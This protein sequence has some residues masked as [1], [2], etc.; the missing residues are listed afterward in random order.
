MS[1]GWG[2]TETDPERGA[3][4]H[5]A[6]DHTSRPVPGRLGIGLNVLVQVLLSIAIFAGVNYLGYRYYMR[7]DLTPNESHTLSSTTLNFLRKLS[8]DVQMTLLFSRGSRVA[9]DMEALADEYR[10][11][12]KK[13]IKVQFID[14]AR[15]VER[16]EQLK[17]E[18]GVTLSQN[19]VLIRANE[20][21][22]YITE[23]EILIKSPGNDTTRPV[24]GFRG[25]DAV[26]SALI[27]VL[28]GRQRIFYVVA[29]KG[30]RS[31]DSLMGALNN[32]RDI[33]RKQNFE[34]KVLTLAELTAVP[35]DADGVILAGPRYDFSDREMAIVRDYWNRKR[36]TVLVLLDPASQTPRLDAFLTEYGVKPRGDRVLFAESTGAGPRKEFSVQA[37]FNAEFSITRPQ[38]DAVT[39]LSGQTES[40]QIL[41]D[42]PRLREQSV[43]VEP[44]IIA[45]PR[46]WGERN[47]LDEL[48]VAGEGDATAPVYVAAAV[49]RGAVPDP[50]LRV[51]SARL[52][53]VGNCDLLDRQT[54]LAANEDFITN[55]LNW[56]MNREKLI[57]IP[58]KVKS[59]YRIQLS[60]HQHDLLFWLTSLAAPG[61]VLSLGLV[62]WASRRAA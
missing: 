19:G 7:W 6:G 40:L 16:A 44:L 31:G 1:A 60:S 42:D 46:Y 18:S 21:T 4:S 49:E 61:L 37:G 36:A 25:E 2:I 48:P 17:A 14:P 47:Y 53:V 39:T 11:N 56:M 55:S 15:D 58:S 29:G 23:D 9:D 57:G 28:E 27:S 24:L 35:A 22:R 32:L 51:D 43:I 38:S 41:T 50:R 33:G 3:S 30:A 12:G 5:G 20:R 8:K 34:L 13:R 26:T 59:S 54:M 52:V 10:R 45:S 62:V